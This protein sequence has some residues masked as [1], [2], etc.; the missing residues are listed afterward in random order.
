ML[1][2]L[3]RTVRQWEFKNLQHFPNL[4]ELQMVNFSHQNWNIGIELYN[5]QDKRPEL[6]SIYVRED[7]LAMILDASES[8]HSVE[9]D[10]ILNFVVDF[11]D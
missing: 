10:R 8:D 7:G 4:H 3:A 6:Q 11:C 2:K 5:F 9:F 1:R